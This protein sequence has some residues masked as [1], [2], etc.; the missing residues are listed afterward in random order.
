MVKKSEEENLHAH[1][2]SITINN[3]LVTFEAPLPKDMVVAVKQME[4]Y[5]AP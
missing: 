5:A 4:K 1:K 3:E 2:L